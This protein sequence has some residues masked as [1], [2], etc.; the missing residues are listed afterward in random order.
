MLK[1]IIHEHKGDL[2]ADVKMEDSIAVDTET[3]GLSYHRDA[4]CVVQLSSGN[5]EA[6]VIQLE[7]TYNCPNLKRILAN[8]SILK[9][10][11]FARF[12]IATIKRWLNVDTKPLWCT[13]IASKLAR[14]YTDKHSLKYIVSELTGTELSKAAQS[15]DW[16]AETLT[17]E[18]VKYAADD[19]LYLHR[20][21]GKLEKILKRENRLDLAQACFDFLPVRAK[22]DLEGWEGKDIFAHT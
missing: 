14:T 5:G 7:R 19:V 6:H 16:G 15:S 21:K 8:E 12:D 11:H 2:P 10:F 4:L 18:Q 13:K 22:L 17:N 1:P 3:M 9:I 20:A